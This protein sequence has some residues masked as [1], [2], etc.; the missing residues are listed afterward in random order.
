FPTCP[1][2]LL[3]HTDSHISLT[4]YTP[5]LDHYWDRTRPHARWYLG[6]DLDDSGTLA[7]SF[8]GIINIGG[9]NRYASNAYFHRQSRR[10][11]WQPVGQHQAIHSLRR[12]LSF[13][14]AEDLDVV[15]HRL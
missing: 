14:S 15:P 8:T 11:Q 13:A 7:R 12:V 6:I 9:V 4:R 3:P 1:A 10:R 2:E 5:D